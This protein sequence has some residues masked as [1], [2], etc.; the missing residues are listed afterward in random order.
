MNELGKR[1]EAFLFIIDFL[2]NEAV[3]VKIKDID[4]GKIMFSFD[5]F[6][7]Y[8]E[9]IIDKPLLFE[10]YPCDFKQYGMSFGKVIKEIQAGNTYLLNLTFQTEIKFN[11]SL[12]DLFYKSRSKYK[13]RYDNRFVVFSPELFVR[14]KD[15]KIYSYPM[16][17]T[18]DANIP[19]AEDSILKDIKETAEH[20]TITDL[21]R[22]DLNM[23]A[24]NVKVERF[25][26]IDRIQT[27]QKDLLQVSSE[28]SGDLAQDYNE[29]LGDIFATLMPAGS[30]TGAPKQKTVEIIR[31]TEN[32]NRGYYTGVA[33]YYDGKDVESFV[34][35]RFIE[36]LNGKFFYKSGGG[37]TYLSKAEEEYREMM[38]KIYI[39][40]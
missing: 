18:I 4:P 31:C 12:E 2:F 7:N 8:E 39:P 3:V 14:I 34:M 9:K 23:V 17:G 36:Q 21:I 40:I 22:N 10:K 32:Y 25:R 26:Y 19:G 27:N 24:D 29:H 5:T 37:I 30:V 11:Y 16:K 38:D 35:I 1:Q 33:G 20:F 6:K 15:S 13:L 28:I